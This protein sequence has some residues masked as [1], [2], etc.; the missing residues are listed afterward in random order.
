MTQQLNTGIDPVSALRFDSEQGCYLPAKEHYDAL[1]RLERAVRRRDESALIRAM[2][3]AKA[4]S[5][6][7]EA[8]A[9]AA[10]LAGHDDEAFR[11]EGLYAMW[12]WN[13]AC[14]ALHRLRR[15]RAKEQSSRMLRAYARAPRVSYTR[16]RSERRRTPRRSVS[17]GSLGGDSGDSDGS[18]SDGDPPPRPALRVVRGGA[19]STTGARGLLFAIRGGAA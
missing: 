12:P 17:S 2:T 5:D 18:G 19:E 15:H 16:C 4:R 7:A 13:P 6:E 3:E 11:A 14:A 10:Y 8:R 1:R 9:E